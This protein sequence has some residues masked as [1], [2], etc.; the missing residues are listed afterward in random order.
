MPIDLPSGCV[1]EWQPS[2]TPAP[3]R[4]R[5]A[6]GTNAQSYVRAGRH[7]SFSVSLHAM[8]SAK[9]A[10]WSELDDESEAVAWP[11]PQDHLISGSEGAPRVA[12]GGQLGSTLNIDGVTAGLILPKDLFIAVITGG[13]RYV[14]RLKSAVTV[15]G[16]GTAALSL[17]PIIRAVHADNDVVELVSPRVEGFARFTGFV[18]QPRRGNLTKPTSFTIEELG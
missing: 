16:T 10:E 11:I 4:S 5:S 13:Q 2:L 7:W 8:A 6:F 15:S 12:G 9:A 3:N 17:R 1:A 14:Y 18:T